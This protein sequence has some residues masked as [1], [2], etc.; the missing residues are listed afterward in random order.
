MQKPFIWLL[1]CF[2]LI[3]SCKKET[4]SIEPK[5]DAKTEN[6]FVWEG[7]NLYF[8]LT[9]RFN[10]GNTENDVNFDRTKETG[11]LRD[12][13]GGDLAGITQKIKDGYFTDLGIN[14]IWFTPVVEQIHDAVD[15]G[16]GN[17]YAY[18]GYWAKDWTAL[19]PN[20]GTYAELQE[21]VKAAHKKGIRI[22]MD[23]VLN[24][25]GPVTDQDPFWGENW[26][27]QEPQCTYTG[28]DTT[29][30]CTLVANLPDIKTDSEVEV[31]L[32]EFLIQKWKDEGRYD[33]EIQELDTYFAETNLP[34]TPRNY[35]I[36]WL[37]DYIRELGID[38]FRVDTV[39]HVDE[40]AWTDLRTQADLAFADYKENNPE[41]ILDDNPFFMLGEVYGYG[42]GGGRDYN[43][44]DNTVDY[45][46]NGFDNLI[47]FQFKYDAKGDYETMFK[48]YDSI[49]H[50]SLEGKSILNY[51]TSHDDGDPFDKDRSKAYE[52]G[53][54]LLLTPGISQ[55]YYGDELARDL[56]IEGTEGD[57][58]LRG[59]MPWNTLDSTETKNILKH[60]QKLG[61]FR[62]DHPA[63]GAGQHQMLQQEPYVFSRTYAKNGVEDAVVIGLDLPVG[64]KRIPVGAIF[65]EGTKLKDTYSN[66]EVTVENGIVMLNNS[67]TLVLLERK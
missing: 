48:T 18:H 50:H 1:C 54:K 66:T 45:F 12:F 29:I 3:L 14:A 27:R 47:N 32:P 37:T 9:D 46:A 61:T 65:A 40:S 17:T 55:V 20:F 34:R 43:F 4:K 7:A 44:G 42:I 10:N 63:V 30:P 41:A 23:V 60:W 24:H 13:K 52:T 56:T 33:T 26:T 15:E 5:A 67:E 59:M 2:W 22:V 25:T 35:I 62:R 19:D 39:K 58:T 64:E 21:L 11:L 8:L 51:A 31:E 16:T 28:Y 6:A 53:T 38:A 49:L 36:K 57:A